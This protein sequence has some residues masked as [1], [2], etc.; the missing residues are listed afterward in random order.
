MIVGLVLLGM[1]AGTTLGATALLS[2]ASIGMAIAIYAGIGCLA[3]L[4]AAAILFAKGET[5][6]TRQAKQMSTQ[7]QN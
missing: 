4:C 5:S 7:L 1:I 2:G 3:M 6:N